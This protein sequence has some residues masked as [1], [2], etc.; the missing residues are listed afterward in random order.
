MGNTKAQKQVFRIYRRLLP[1]LLSRDLKIK[2]QRSLL[3][4]IWTLIN[5]LLVSVVLITVFSLVVRIPIED[6]WAFLL[7]GYF[8]W[9]F[10][11]QCIF[12]AASIFQQHA[13]L[14]KNI[15]FPTEILVLSAALSRLIEFLAELVIVTLLICYIHHQAVPPALLLLPLAV[16]IQILIALGFMFPISVTSVLFQ[17]LQHALPSFIL[18]LFYVSPILY[19]LAFVPELALPWYYLNPLVPP[20]EL[21]HAIL[22]QGT[23]PSLSALAASLLS[24]AIFCCLGYLVFRRFKGECIEAA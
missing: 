22:Y 24:A 19:P 21:Y 14:R 18:S 6:Y 17:D 2:Y 15:A 16:S 3:G 10:M 11:Q 9:N 20:L 23:S 4:F 7:S 5:P 1:S 8:A 12:A 13:A